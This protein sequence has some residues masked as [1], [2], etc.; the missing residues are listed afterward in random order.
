MNWNFGKR[1]ESL[2]HFAK[3]GH[4]QV[5]AG[6]YDSDPEQISQWLDTVVGSKIPNVQGV[7]YT[8][9]R[10]KY[11]DLEEFAGLVRSHRWYTSSKR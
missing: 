10:R 6:Y 3:R 1:E 4:S 8:T 7:M 5:L 2:N 11:S 9:W